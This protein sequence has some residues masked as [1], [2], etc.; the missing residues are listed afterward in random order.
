MA[1]LSSLTSLIH[2]RHGSARPRRV[3]WPRPAVEELEP[4][5]APST[6]PP[7][8][9]V[10]AFSPGSDGGGFVPTT[11]AS[12]QA[13]QQTAALNPP[14]PNPGTAMLNPAGTLGGTVTQNGVVTNPAFVA[15]SLI[16]NRVPILAEFQPVSVFGRLLNSN[17]NLPSGT[18]LL[19][20]GV[21][22]TN[23]LLLQ[24]TALRSGSGNDF[25]RV[26]TTDN[27]MMRRRM[28]DF[29]QG[30]PG[31]ENYPGPGRQPQQTPRLETALPQS[32]RERPQITQEVAQSVRQQTVES[33][34]MAE[35]VEYLSQGGSLVE[36]AAMLSRTGE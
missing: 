36:L 17:A 20:I 5:W 9:G 34:P 24:R 1:F 31:L 21:S 27:E 19:P 11:F 32:L 3:S 26:F 15:Q 28:R 8:V 4:R 14:V 29:M 2:G 12:G 30:L 6:T 35:L 23:L 25:A 22:N 13:D 16:L 33:T 10:G 18:A 7:P